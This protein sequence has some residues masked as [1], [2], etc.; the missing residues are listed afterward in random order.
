MK[1]IKNDKA[2]QL[3][4]EDEKSLELILNYY[5][6]N[7]SDNWDDKLNESSVIMQINNLLRN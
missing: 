3:N 1:I 2:I 6:W 5:L 7:I 4:E